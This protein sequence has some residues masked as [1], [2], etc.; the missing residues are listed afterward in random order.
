[1]LIAKKALLLVA[2]AFSL[3][4]IR[5]A[6]AN[7]YPAPVDPEP[8]PGAPPQDGASSS[9]PDFFEGKIS[10]QHMTS[11][12]GTRDGDDPDRVWHV[13]KFLNHYLEKTQDKRVGVFWAGG[14]TTEEDFDN[15]NEFQELPVNF[16]GV[17]A[18]DVFENSI[19]E[20]MGLSW[21]NKN[22]LWWRAINRACK[23]LAAGCTG[24]TAYVYMNNN[25]CRTLFSPPS[26]RPLDA[27]PDHGGVA[28]NGEI[29]YYSELP[30]LMR[31]TNIKQ[32]VTF[33][34]KPNDH[35]FTRDV[36]WDVDRDTDKPRDFLQDIAMD[37]A[38]IIIPPEMGRPPLKRDVID[39][40]W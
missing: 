12:D 21:Y 27:D 15:I 8:A 31:N 19:F 33:Y 28:T 32:I 14:A 17:I 26:K 18:F 24:G 7:P 3:R 6:E 10:W 16:Q 1:M 11:G 4:L 29:W 5:I 9:P 38:P 25:N 20:S 40:V 22:N 34:K 36:A 23:A 39:I 30:T 2:A 37:A 13:K 35:R